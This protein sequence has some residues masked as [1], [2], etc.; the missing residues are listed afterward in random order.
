MRKQMYR[1]WETI[2]SVL[3]KSIVK[4]DSDESQ[5]LSWLDF[6]WKIIV[7]KD[8]ALVSRVNKLS[9]KSLFVTVSDKA[10][11]SSLESL[12]EKTIHMI[13]DRAGSVL[14]NRIVFQEGFILDV[15]IKNSYEKK[16]QYSL[17]GNKAEI[18]ETVVKDE[19]MQTIL[20]RISFKLKIVLPV[21]ILIFVSNCTTYSRDLVSQN[22]DLSN[23]YAVQA[24]EKISRGKDRENI[25]DPR[26]Y[27]HYLMALQGVRGHQFEQASDNFSKVVQFAPGDYEFYLQSAINLI[28]A[29]KIEN[30]YRTLEE[31]LGH[32]PDN[33]ELNMMIGDIHSRRLEYEKALGHYQRVAQTKLSSAR[34]LLLSGAIYEIRQQYDL[35][36][37][38]YKKLLQ[39]EPNNPLG[40]FYLART[41]I[42]AG[43]LEDAKGFLNQTLELRPN[44]LHAREFLAWVL[45]AQGKPDEAKKQYKKFLKLDPFN[46]KIQKRMTAMKYTNLPMNVGSSIYLTTA[47]E[48][49]GAPEVHMKIG[50]VYYEQGIYLKALDEFQLLKGKK[51][52][53]KISMVLGRIYEVLGRID[54][55]I[56]EINTLMK[57]EPRSTHLMIYLARL[58]SMNKQPKKTVQLIEEAIKLDENNDILY[59]TLAIAFIENDQLD[60]AIDSMQ[61]A[62][63]INKDKDSYYFELGALLQR[64][65]E[66]E[67]AIKN[68]K[69]SIELNPMH[70]NAHNFLGYIYAME[71]KSLDKALSHLNKALSIQPKNGFFLDSLSWIYFKK[72]ESGKALR[73]LK[74]AMV[75]TAPDP[76]LYSHLGDIHFSLMNYI[77][78]SKA[79]ETSLFL[80]LEEKDDVGNELPDPKELK[81]KI[82]KV[83][84]FL[85]Y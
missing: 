35:A 82:Q 75:Y 74:K 85:N 80:T 41:K 51:Q 54:L 9:S 45:E 8:L 56:Q 46:E 23:S 52:N 21:A 11:F 40:H 12:R 43:K 65:G 30:A 20:D 84:S 78:A 64:T 32:F 22:I 31:S 15:S 39:I 19:S 14:V 76:V 77:E 6:Q 24:F 81:E 1:S 37:E 18:P 26:V 72:G 5:S 73:E 68:I 57:T 60:K 16:K 59:H 83:K 61:K 25:R 4:V 27:Y 47:K 17:M 33:P 38:M 49:L 66:F 10:W 70:S 28:R 36:E 67:R 53:N 79:W 69:Y 62:I 48:V 44:L 29:G 42:I 7:G 55:A 58:H 71:G 50:T 13:N 34:A 2:G 63:E 3:G